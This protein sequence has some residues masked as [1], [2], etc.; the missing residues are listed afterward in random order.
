MD[1]ENDFIETFRFKLKE[2][3]N[4]PNKLLYDER[5]L[6][7]FQFLAN[8]L[9]LLLCEY[10]GTYIR[11]KYKIKEFYQCNK[12]KVKEKLEKIAEQINLDIIHKFDSDNLSNEQKR[13][14]IKLEL[15]NELKNNGFKYSELI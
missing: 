4:S 2:I 3:E 6:D 1:E 13:N 7:L 8:N 9:E 5:V 15:Q 11:L 10:P 12:P 14:I